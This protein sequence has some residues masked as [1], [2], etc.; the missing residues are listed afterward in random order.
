MKIQPSISKANVIDTG[1]GLCMF[2]YIYI[3][4]LRGRYVKLSH[5]NCHMIKMKV[6]F[7]IV[8]SRLRCIL[9]D[10]WHLR[11]MTSNYIAWYITIYIYHY[12]NIAIIYHFQYWTR[13]ILLLNSTAPCRLPGHKQLRLF[14]QLRSTKDNA[15][16]MAL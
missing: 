7:S 6:D 3:Y 9:R 12:H 16:T 11:E 1:N 2:I 8:T 15:F 5:H 10:E 4:I 13:R 14:V